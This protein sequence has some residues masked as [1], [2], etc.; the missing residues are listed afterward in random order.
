MQA[1][2]RLMAVYTDIINEAQEKGLELGIK[3]GRLEG[4]TEG[5]TEGERAVLVRLLTR[6]FGPLPKSAAARIRRANLATLERWT[7]CVLTARTLDDVL[8]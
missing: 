1:F 7:D 2:Q 5:V 6:R 4:V 3:K 8:D